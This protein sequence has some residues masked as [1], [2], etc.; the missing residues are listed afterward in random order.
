MVETR[1]C[2]NCLEWGHLGKDCK[3]PD[4]RKAVA[5]SLANSEAES[6]GGSQSGSVR[7]LASAQG[8][9]KRLCMMK[10]V[11][12]DG[13]TTKTR[14]P[15]NPVLSHNMYNSPLYHSDPETSYSNSSNPAAID[16]ISTVSMFQ[17]LVADEP[18]SEGEILDTKS[19]VEN[20]AK[21]TM[22]KRQRTRHKAETATGA[23]KAIQIP[24]RKDNVM[25]MR[26]LVHIELIS[27]QH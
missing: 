20:R 14:S 4:R 18:N 17:P 6:Q 26:D 13:W 24:L 15:G 19:A 5:R 16:P 8:G 2:Y 27:P 23:R 12:A 3:H 11:D 1:Q 25:Q 7:S 22:T 21:I 9:M 10:V